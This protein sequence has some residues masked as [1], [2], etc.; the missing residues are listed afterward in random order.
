MSDHMSRYRKDTTGL[1]NSPGR[2]NPGP[3]LLF[4]TLNL[5]H[6][7][8]HGILGESLLRFKKS[9]SGLGW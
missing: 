8:R 2:S 9:W 7:S 6:D 5:S 4:F 3:E 1:T